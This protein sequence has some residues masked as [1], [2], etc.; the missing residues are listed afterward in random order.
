MTHLNCAYIDIIYYLFLLTYIPSSIQHYY[1][2]SAEL[3]FGFWR[4]YSSLD[5][6]IHANGSTT[7]PPPRR[8]MFK[9]T[10][11]AHWRDYAHMNELV[12]RSTFPALAS[13][14]KDDWEERAASRR[15]YVFDRVVL[16][17]RSSAMLGF[18]YHRSQR[19]ASEPFVLPGSANWWATIRNNIIEFIGGQVDV[20]SSNLVITYI[21][22]QD[23]G[24][25]MLIP[26]DHDRLVQ[27][28]YRLR[29][30]Y[31]YEINVVS[32]DKMSRIEQLE[33]SARTTVSPFF[34]LFH[35]HS[36]HLVFIFY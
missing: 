14:F 22:R 16:A 7:L 12:L 6:H 23:W 1:H 24:R 8:M 2:W 36:F 30:T 35:L 17:D 25:R 5:P 11:S 20:D 4:M 13:E 21:S 34:Y 26:A 32:M 28:L 29:D 10:D 31:G 27:E 33:L 15:A 18:N 3:F 19:T 9:H